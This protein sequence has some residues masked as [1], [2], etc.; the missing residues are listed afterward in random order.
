[1]IREKISG[2]FNMKKILAGGLAAVLLIGVILAGGFV[3]HFGVDTSE[4]IVRVALGG[5][6]SST[7]SMIW[8]EDVHNL[9]HNA[10]KSDFIVTG[11]VA[12]VGGGKWGTPSGERPEGEIGLK[13]IEGIHHVVTID[14]NETF[15][16]PEKD[17]IRI[18]VNSGSKG[19]YLHENRYAPD[20]NEGEEVLVYVQRWEGNYETLNMKYSKFN[21]DQEVIRKPDA[22]EK[23]RQ[24]I[25]VSELLGNLRERYG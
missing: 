5:G 1:M 6:V 7:S 10:N 20:Y 19:L 18:R 13:E 3:A 11:T 17:R 23:F 9:T 24:R 15:K 22:P 25:K 14:V 16:A 21:I 4:K 12:D 8:H 2:D